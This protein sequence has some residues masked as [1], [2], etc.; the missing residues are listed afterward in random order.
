MAPL[1][2]PVAALSLFLVLSGCVTSER[3]KVQ[4]YLYRNY[5]NLLKRV[6]GA[7]REG[8]ELAQS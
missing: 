6:D 8:K 4:L 2:N 7:S 1:E 3:E 5:R